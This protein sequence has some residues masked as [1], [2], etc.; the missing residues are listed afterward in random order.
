MR[1][2]MGQGKRPGG[3]RWQGFLLAAAPCALPMPA[4]AAIPDALTFENGNFIVL[5]A[6]ACGGVALAIAAGLWALAEQRAAQRLRRSLR[7]VS[8]KTRA[9]LGEREA[10][11][12]AGR[13]ALVVWGRDGS[14]PFSYGGGE[15]LLQSC[16]KGANALALSSALDGLSDRGAGFQLPVQDSHGRKLVARGR[17][18]GGMAAVWLEEPAIA[19]EE[20]SGHYKAILDALPIPVWLRDKGLALAW[21]NHAFLKGA[22]AQRSGKRA[23]RTGRARSWRARSGRRGAF[24][25]MQCR[26]HGASRW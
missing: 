1:P 9:A 14:G 22:G 3:R 12:S 17:A 8:A 16:L 10:L 21:G 25:A 15:E 11:L 23:P 18:V 2:K 19:Q 26:K 24:P 6:L 20:A 7:A 5:S 4:L 13:E